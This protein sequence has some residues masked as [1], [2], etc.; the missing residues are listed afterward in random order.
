MKE[1]VEEA[2]IDQAAKVYSAASKELNVMDGLQGAGDTAIIILPGNLIQREK[3][4]IEGEIIETKNNDDTSTDTD[5]S[6]VS[7]PSS[8]D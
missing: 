7:V 8:T 4:Y 5:K 6:G 1:K 3:N 2:T